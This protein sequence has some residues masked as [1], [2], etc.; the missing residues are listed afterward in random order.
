VIPLIVAVFTASI[1]GSLHC[2]G[3]CGAFLAFAVGA[4]SD[5][6]R[7][8]PSKARLQ[9][10][11]HCGRLV[12]YTA[13]GAV[14]GS[15]G[16]ALDLGGSMVGVQRVAAALAGG[17]MV[18][19]GLIAVLRVSG[20]RVPRAPVPAPMGALLTRGH[21]WAFGMPPGRRS[22]VIGLLTT[23]LPCGWLYAFVI[24]SA[25]T[26][27]PLLGAVTMAVFWLG[28]LP[29]MVA[30]GTGLQALTGA[31]RHRIPLITSLAVV[32]VGI[33]TVAG[34]LALP[35]VS[36]NFAVVPAGLRAATDH[37]HA[38]ESTKPPCCA[39]E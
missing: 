37:A 12:T 29:V 27:S 20:V 8:M 10:A 35:A 7:Q 17:L 28:T 1:L 5:N 34:R 24:T 32:A 26:A 18:G 25:G 21:R 31:L 2:A 36:G 14:A 13:L 11:Y 4:G 33:F 15:L 23:L 3:M 39:D 9:A 22:L 19:F 6:C 38:L 16:A 30:L